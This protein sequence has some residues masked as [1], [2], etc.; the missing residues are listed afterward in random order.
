M[1]ALKKWLKIIALFF[2]A[3]ILFQSCSAYKTPITLE[4]AVQEK[5]K[6]KIITTTNNAFKYNYIVFEDGQFYGVKADYDTREN[7]KIPINSDEV[8]AVTRRGLPTWA[9]IAIAGGVVL[10][11]V[12]VA[13]VESQNFGSPSW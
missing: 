12:I 10:G 2:T 7:I 1:K 6:V 8:V 3:L 4:Q 13:V 11:I 9:W 5:K